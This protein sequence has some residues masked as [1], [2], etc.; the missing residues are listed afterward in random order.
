[1]SGDFIT[2]SKQE[3][4]YI[5]VHQFLLILLVLDSSASPLH[6]IATS[7][8]RYSAE[9]EGQGSFSTDQLLQDVTT[10]LTGDCRSH[11]YIRQIAKR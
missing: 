4:S 10:L 9:P 6:L 5:S 3:Y 8:E 1:M 7:T 2:D 11:F